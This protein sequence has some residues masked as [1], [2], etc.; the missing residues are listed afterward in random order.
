MGK[1]LRLAPKYLNVTFKPVCLGEKRL[2]MIHHDTHH[3]CYNQEHMCKEHI[4]GC[5]CDRICETERT[6]YFEEPFDH[7]LYPLSKLAS[8]TVPL[9]FIAEELQRRKS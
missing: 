6:W 8:F 1:C 3:L 5:R 4:T 9:I 2:E 7:I